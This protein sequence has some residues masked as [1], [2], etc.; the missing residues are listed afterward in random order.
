M[1]LGVL[2]Y[3]LNGLDVWEG[4]LILLRQQY[5]NDVYSLFYCGDFVSIVCIYKFGGAG[6]CR[7]D[8]CKAMLLQCMPEELLKYLKRNMRPA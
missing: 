6:I 8:D 1:E 7:R 3:W 2:L 5:Y 4:L